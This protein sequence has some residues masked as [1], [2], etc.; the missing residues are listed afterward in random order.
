[1]GNASGS[2]AEGSIS[3]TRL[4]RENPVGK[5]GAFELGLEE[6]ESCRREEAEDKA[7]A[8]VGG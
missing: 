3:T 2:P 8:G 1:M 5:K 7:A 4:S 6:S